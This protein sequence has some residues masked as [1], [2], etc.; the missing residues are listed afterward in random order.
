MFTPFKFTLLP[1]LVP[2]CQVGRKVDVAEK[3]SQNITHFE[4]LGDDQSLYS[5]LQFPKYIKNLFFVPLL[6][7]MK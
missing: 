7:E 2:H 4:P 3:G 6:R 1:S 5:T